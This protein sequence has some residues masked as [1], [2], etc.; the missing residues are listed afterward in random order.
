[1]NTMSKKIYLELS[2]PGTGDLIADR[3]RLQNAYRFS[4]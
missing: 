3:E 4:P 2:V 1:M